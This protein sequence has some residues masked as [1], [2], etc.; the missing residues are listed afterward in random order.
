MT[1]R[2]PTLLSTYLCED[3]LAGLTGRLTLYNLFGEQYA[4]AWPAIVP[5][6]AVSNTW[7]LEE[8]SG[9]TF[10][11]RVVILTPD[12]Q[13]TVAE[14]ATS[15]RFDGA[16]HT[17]VS[18]FADVVLPAPGIYRVQVWLGRELRADYPLTVLNVERS[19]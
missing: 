12:R 7:L 18:R 3:A 1:D 5:R 16:L 4:T 10:T 19:T 15:W 17:N 13:T 8:P 11:E 14:A 9:N 6:F 2:Q